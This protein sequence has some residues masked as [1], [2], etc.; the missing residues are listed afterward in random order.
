MKRF[1]NKV[2]KSENGCWYWLG[3]GADGYGRFRWKGTTTYAYRASYEIYKGDIPDGYIIHHKCQ[4]PNCVNPDHLQACTRSEHAMISDHWN[5]R[6]TH[7]K[8]GHEFTPENTAQYGGRNSRICR[9]CSNENKNKK[10]KLARE[11]GEKYW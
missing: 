1:L 4:N 3:A 5:R 7:C 11:R 9:A 8:R 6:K 2:H 10:R